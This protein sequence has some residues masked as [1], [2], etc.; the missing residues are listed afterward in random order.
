MLRL[1]KASKFKGI[2]YFSNVHCQSDISTEAFNDKDIV[3]IAAGFMTLDTPQ[4]LQSAMLNGFIEFKNVETESISSSGVRTINGIYFKKL[5]QS[6]FLRWDIFYLDMAQS[7]L[8][9]YIKKQ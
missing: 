7:V 1:D 9:Y 3:N 8:L 4:V 6:L 5:E 2:L